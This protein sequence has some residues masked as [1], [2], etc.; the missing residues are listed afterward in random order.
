MPSAED[1]FVVEDEWERLDRL[2]ME[3]QIAFDN[4]DH[5]SPAR[6]VEAAKVLRFMAQSPER[7]VF[8]VFVE[9]LHGGALLRA[10]ASPNREMAAIIRETVVET[11]RRLK[12]DWPSED[13]RRALLSLQPDTP[14]ARAD[15]RRWEQTIKGGDELERMTGYTEVKI[16]H[17]PHRARRHLGL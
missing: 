3:T 4:L 6:Q 1:S 9:N 8:G 12:I 11:A 10:Q 16:P 5:P 14:S 17:R 15:Q 13:G 7:N 2:A